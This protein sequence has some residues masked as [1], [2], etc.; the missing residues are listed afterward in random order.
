[1]KRENI[2]ILGGGGIG[3]AAGLILA[4]NALFDYHITIGD[5]LEHA[6]RNAE[7]FINEGAHCERCQSIITPSSGLNDEM[8]ELLKSTDIILDCLPGS[9]APRIAQYAKDYNCHYANLTEHVRETEEVINIAAGAETGF[10]LQ[11][12]L[13]PG[14]INVLAMYLF[15]KFTSTYNVEK[16]DSVN[17]KVGALSKHAREPYFYAYTWSPIGVATEY[18]KDSFVVRDYNTVQIPSLSQTES[19]LID[20]IK[21]E[22]DYTSGGAADLPQALSGK[23]K[24]LNYKTLRF[25]GHYN[26]ARSVINE[27]P[28]GHDPVDHL[29]NTMMNTIP[30]VEDDHVVVFASVKAKDEY[31][32]LRAM[33][34]SINIYPSEV[35]TKTLRAIQ[36][37]TAAPLCE[38]ARILLMD[39][40]KGP[41]LQSQLN[42]I[43]FLNGPFVSDIYGKIED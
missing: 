13:A 29:H 25:P 24:D 21:Y 33:E 31:G 5:R 11:T 26:W 20:G 9:E 17:M 7:K 14:Y 16:V 38:A 34:K 1:M 37:A 19:I 18:V 39:G 28:L 10:V 30:S 35:G 22:D 32:I 3:Q 8:K 40:Y 42:P 36:T 23:V 2:L 43:E 41:I 15:N 4:K 27:T 12:G 6:A